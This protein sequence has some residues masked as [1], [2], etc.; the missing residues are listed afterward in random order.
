[1]GFALLPKTLPSTSLSK[2]FNWPRKRLPFLPWRKIL[3]PCHISLWTFGLNRTT[4]EFR[5]YSIKFS[6]CVLCEPLVVLEICIRLLW[7][8]M[9]DL[10]NQLF[11]KVYMYTTKRDRDLSSI[12]CN[13]LTSFRFWQTRMVL[14]L[15]VMI[16]ILC[17]KVFA[18]LQRSKNRSSSIVLI[19]HLYVL[20]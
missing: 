1:M 20:Q 18:L 14:R 11:I 7:I 19:I 17:L 8:G 15:T 13:E 16:H 6:D 2:T 12:Y 10:M 5:S 9:F 3:Y 4:W